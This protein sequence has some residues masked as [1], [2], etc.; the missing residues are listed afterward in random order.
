L[1]EDV[2]GRVAVLIVA[3]LLQFLDWPILDP[4][5]SVMFTLFILFNVVRNLWDTGKLFLQGA[6]DKVMHRET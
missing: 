3:I 2:L 1:L 5:L 6:P 4:L